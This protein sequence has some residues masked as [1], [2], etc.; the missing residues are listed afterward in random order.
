M[1][2]YVPLRPI[3]SKKEPIKSQL[4]IPAELHAL[5]VEATQETGRSMN[6]EIVQRLQDSFSGS[7]A[8]EP[9]VRVAME[10]LAKKVNAYNTVVMALI[11]DVDPDSKRHAARVAL[12]RKLTGQDVV[13][14][15]AKNQRELGDNAHQMG[16]QRH[17]QNSAKHSSKQ[18]VQFER[19]GKEPTADSTRQSEKA[20]K[21]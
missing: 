11:R 8:N 6:A 21:R 13:D 17:V 19:A 18:A 16:G 15:A 14:P 5:L 2:P 7:I 3:M 10:D 9:D 12:V 1:P 20:R 4:R